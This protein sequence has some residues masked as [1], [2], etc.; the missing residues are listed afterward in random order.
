MTSNPVMDGVLDRAGVY[1][2]KNKEL[3]SNLGEGSEKWFI[4]QVGS[5]AGQLLEG[6]ARLKNTY[7]MAAFVGALNELSKIKSRKEG[8]DKVKIAQMATMVSKVLPSFKE[9]QPEDFGKYSE[10]LLPGILGVV[11]NIGLE[12]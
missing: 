7:D 5:V 1:I 2:T 9:M 4:V 12:D 8:D 3:F 10:K 6:M 11:Y